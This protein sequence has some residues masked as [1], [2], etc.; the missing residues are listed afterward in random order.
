MIFNRN[1]ESVAEKRKRERLEAESAKQ[2]A[3]IDYLAMMSDIEIPGEE[4]VSN[5][6]Q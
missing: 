6:Q 3:D 1:T 5:E 2:Q 4:D